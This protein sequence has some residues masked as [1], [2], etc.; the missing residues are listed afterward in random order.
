MLS[1]PCPRGPQG[2]VGTS[3]RKT[4]IQG[5]TECLLGGARAWGLATRSG[6]GRWFFQ[7]APAAGGGAASGR[8]GAGAPP[9]EKKQLIMA[10]QL[11]PTKK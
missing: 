6:P 11:G 10:V 7:T 3:L 2:T 4:F 1:D 8:A 9:G 5:G